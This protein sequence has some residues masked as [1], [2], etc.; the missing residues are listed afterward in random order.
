MGHGMAWHGVARGVCLSLRATKGIKNLRHSGTALFPAPLCQGK[1]FHAGSSKRIGASGEFNSSETVVSVFVHTYTCWSF[2]FGGK[3][4]LHFL[5]LFHGCLPFV[6]I[7]DATS[8]YLFRAKTHA[9]MH[10]E[11]WILS[12][13]CDK[14]AKHPRIVNPKGC[15]CRVIDVALQI[16]SKFPKRGKN[17]ALGNKSSRINRIN[18]ER[19]TGKSLNWVGKCNLKR[20]MQGVA[21]WKKKKEQKRRNKIFSSRSKALFSRKTILEFS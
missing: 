4:I 11:R 5:S 6:Q 20:S 13:L 1:H 3:F 8:S 12:I 17:S 14:V 16:F 10:D 2:P 15:Y 7:F 21:K 19:V 9:R 18:L